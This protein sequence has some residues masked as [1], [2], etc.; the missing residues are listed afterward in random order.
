MKAKAICGCYRRDEA[1]DPET[2]AVALALVFGDY[3]ASVVDFVADPRTGVITEYKMGMPNVGQIKEFCDSILARQK[4]LEQYAA[5]P[6]YER[7]A[8]RAPDPMRPG[9][10]YFDMF[11]KHG[12]PKGRFES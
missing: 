2:F 3:P 12:R 4:K 1:Q 7:P 8:Y 11:A 9:T 10:S 6:R 5:A